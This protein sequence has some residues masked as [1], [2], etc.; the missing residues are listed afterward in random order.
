MFKKIFVRD[1]FAFGL[2]LGLVLPTVF[3]FILN[4]LDFLVFSIFNTHLLAQHD[5]LFI[6]SLAINLIAI[7]YYF[8]NLKYD[9]TGQGVLIVTFAIALAYFALF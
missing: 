4:K 9:K 5:Y 6:L 8:V 3:Y 1:H 2:L 7:R